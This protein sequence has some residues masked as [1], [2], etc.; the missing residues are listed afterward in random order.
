[1]IMIKN[2]ALYESAKSFVVAAI[3]LL[4]VSLQSIDTVRPALPWYY[5]RTLGKQIQ[6]LPDFT[7]CN[8]I[9][10]NDP[11]LSKQI[12]CLV[13]SWYGAYYMT[14]FEYLG[15]LIAKQFANT[16]EKTAFS[17]ERFDRAY[18]D[19][20][21]LLYEEKFPV[22]AHSPLHNFDSDV[23]SLELEN[24][25]C[26]RKIIS[27][28]KETQ[29]ARSV[30]DEKL[31]YG[32]LAPKYIIEFKFET[33][34][35]VGPKNVSNNPPLNEN[36]HEMINR[37]LT[38]LRLFKS[39]RV[40]IHT[41]ETIQVLD[42]LPIYSHASGNSFNG[43]SFGNTYFLSRQEIESFKQLWKVVNRANVESL[44]CIKISIRRFQY[45]YERVNL[46]D[47]IIDYMIAFEALLFKE[48]E[49]GELSHKLSTRVAKLLEETFDERVSTAKKMQVFYK[50]RSQVVHG[51][52]IRVDANFAQTIEEYLRKSI[53]SVIERLQIL[54]HDQIL[55]HLDLE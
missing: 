47:K 31:R 22:M 15:H 33:T 39:G 23:D 32:I 45:A 53:I 7:A 8:K 46:E 16:Y 9:M 24:G 14:V 26:I 19:L 41:V 12:D 2:K 54:E 37:V 44:E 5:I 40:G 29:L 10:H 27:K 50:A 55:L 28:D 51:E 43:P 18:L 30:Y 13:G 1:M 17:L 38:A 21:Q 20:E 49:T 36:E 34:K 35:I 4:D 42:L 48:G 3:Q 25:L 6:N 52:K 11:L